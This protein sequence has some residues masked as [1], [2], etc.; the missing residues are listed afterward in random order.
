M[1]ARRPPK[2]PVSDFQ[3]LADFCHVKD[4]RVELHVDNGLWTLKV[5]DGRKVV[6]KE[7]LRGEPP[8][9]LDQLALD[10]AL[11]LVKAGRLAK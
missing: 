7:N 6:A 9:V 2:I 1:M 4:W 10:A 11:T 8:Q 3:D 5:L